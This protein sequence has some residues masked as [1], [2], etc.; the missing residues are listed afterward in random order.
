M[1]KNEQDGH[2]CTNGGE[3]KPMP[4]IHEW[5]VEKKHEGNKGNWRH[6]NLMALHFLMLK[7]EQDGHEYTN[8]G[9]S[10]E[11]IATNS[12]MGVVEM[13]PMPR[14]HEW[15]VE[16]KPMPRMYEWVVEKTLR[17]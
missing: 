13:K 5:V 1:L 9:V 10:S 11:N 12:R 4:R 16:V 2:E 3:M 15:V 14:I 8:E 17:H 7:N 6:D